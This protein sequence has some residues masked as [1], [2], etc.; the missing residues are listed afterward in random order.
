MKQQEICT[1]I[2]NKK[3]RDMKRSEY[4]EQEMKV[5]ST[6][7]LCL[8]DEILYEVLAKTSVSGLSMKFEKLY[9]EVPQQ[10]VVFEVTPIHTSDEARICTS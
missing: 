3:P 2:I 7:L 5:H 9:D 4:D 6:I 8:Y 10:Q 1:L